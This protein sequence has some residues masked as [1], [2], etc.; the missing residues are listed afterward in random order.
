MK[1]IIL[2]CLILS[3]YQFTWSQEQ[4]DYYILDRQH[5][6]ELRKNDELTFTKEVKGRSEKERKKSGQG[7]SKKQDD[8]EKASSEPV[9]INLGP[10]LQIVFIV[11]FI[12]LIAALLFLLVGN[13]LTGKKN[14]SIKQEDL[15]SDESE[16][17]LDQDKVLQERLE[18]AIQD[19]NFKMVI[20]IYFLMIIKQMDEAK[21]INRTKEKTNRDYLFEVQGMAFYE[22]FSKLCFWYDLV[23]YGDKHYSDESLK[24]L[25]DQFSSF[26]NQLKLELK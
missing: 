2:S 3:L 18:K 21:V 5:W 12:A 22:G 10:I 1:K 7:S 6:D 23:W 13:E 9:F 24:S 14:K 15:E 26:R 16:W 17:E 25:S 19:K 20:R 8:E 4:E 11:L